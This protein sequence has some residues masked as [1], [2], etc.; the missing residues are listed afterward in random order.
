MFK[1]S[2]LSEETSVLQ[3]LKNLDF[4]LLISL[5]T[6]GLVSLA[7]MYST[8]GG[9]ILFHTKSHAVKLLTFFPMMIILS[10]I[11]IRFW[12]SS[13]YLIYFLVL[14]LLCLFELADPIVFSPEYVL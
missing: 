3:K 1:Q 6:L 11:N 7:S 5:F 12:H 13:G 10:L 14:I 2:K 9:Q 8:D 4:V